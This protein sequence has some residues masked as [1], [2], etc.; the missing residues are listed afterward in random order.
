VGAIPVGAKVNV[1]NALTIL[2]K[3]HGGSG[4]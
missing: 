4:G 1:V 3:P 2:G